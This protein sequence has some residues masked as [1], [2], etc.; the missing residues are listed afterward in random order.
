MPLGRS[1]DGQQ[2]PGEVRYY[3]VGD[4]MVD[5]VFPDGPRQVFWPYGGFNLEA[6]DAHGGWIASALDLARFAARLD[7]PAR[8]GV[9]KSETFETMYAPPPPPA[10][11]KPDGALEDRFY[12]CG[13]M[14][15]PSGNGARGTYWHSGSL[16]GTAT[17]LTRR[18]DGLSWVA[19]FNQRS[20]SKELP[21]S[22]IDT[23]K[24]GRAHV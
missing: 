16:P 12:S 20:A 11:R 19:L 24:I 4:E 15:R 1:L 14:T 21:D 23:A 9:L 3:M 22:A 8:S 7:N 10:S 13:W 2:A 18:T 17:F 5:N 6:M